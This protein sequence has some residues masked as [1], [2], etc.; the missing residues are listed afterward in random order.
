M[1]LSTTLKFSALS[2]AMLVGASLHAQ[3]W[4]VGEPVDMLIYG[5]TYY[6]GCN[7]SPDYSFQLPSS[8]VTG[9]DYKLVIT[10]IDPPT[11][12]LTVVPG[13][14]D[15]GVGASMVIDA[16]VT[17]SVI[18]ATGTNSAVIEMRAIGTPTT[19]GQA[20]PCGTSAFWMSNLMFCPEGLTPVI[21]NGCT[22]QLATGVEAPA[23]VDTRIQWPSAAN[24]QQL[25]IDLPGQEYSTAR[26]LDVNGRTVAERG[27]GT[28]AT[29]SLGHVPAGIYVLYLAKP[30]GQTSGQRFAVVQ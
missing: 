25:V 27:I 13:M 18:L 26:V 20:H 12:T 24:G 17:R 30:D 9:V 5:Q 10:S 8:P 1:S 28:H 21:D 19:A 14:T 15:A 16:A 4:T 11:G 6:G 2:T 3:A 29:I 7:P 22:V 23:T